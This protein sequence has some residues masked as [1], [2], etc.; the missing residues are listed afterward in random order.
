MAFRN[1][2]T[3]EYPITRD[4]IRRLY[5]NTSFPAQFTQADGF[6]WV[7]DVPAPV[8][9]DVSHYLRQGAPVKEGDTWKQVWEVIPYD[10]DEAA[11]RQQ[12]F[13]AERSADVRKERGVLLLESDWTQVAD[14]PV[15]KAAWATYRQALRD[16]TSQP[17]FPLEVTW[18]EE[19]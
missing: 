5:P 9:A 3:G 7:V 1:S 17:G 10:P 6:D 8:F 14:A 19:P 18:P 4:Q 15:D 12:I 13:E 16:I 2:T 11:Q